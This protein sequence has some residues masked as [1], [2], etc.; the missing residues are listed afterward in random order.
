MSTR[1]PSTRKWP[2]PTNCRAWARVEAEAVDDVVEPALQGDQQLVAGAPPA[3]VG[4]GDVAAELLL[5][6]PVVA[7]GELLGAQLRAEDRGLVRPSLAVLAG[8]QRAAPHQGGL[9]VQG[10]Q[11]L[12]VQLDAFAPGEPLDRPRVTS[13]SYLLLGGWR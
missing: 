4:G 2:W 6:H 5:A 12:Q 10:A 13:H 7:L 8:R 9:A 3:P 11:A 1:R